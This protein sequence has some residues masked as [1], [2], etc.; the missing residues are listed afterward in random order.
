MIDA[1]VHM[2]DPRRFDYPWLSQAPILDRPFIPSDLDGEASG[3]GAIFVQADCAGTQSLDE[4]RWVA[5]LDW[6]GLRGIVAG[7]DLRSPDLSD[8]LDALATVPGV[9]GVRHL[10]QGEDE[11]DWADDDAL[12]AGLR[13]L[14]ARGLTFDACVHRG[15]LTALAPLLESVP[16]VKVVIDHLGKPAVDA[17]IDDA[18]GRQW[19]DSMRRLA[20][21]PLTHVKL[22][23]LAPEAADRSTLDHN[24]DA[25]VTAGLELFGAERAMI[26]SDWPVS[27]RLG[28]GLRP[29]K[30]RDRVL[31]VAASVGADRDAV[32][33]GTA[34]R[35]Y[36]L[37]PTT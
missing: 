31:R 28:A 4:A 10:L 3:Y 17:G 23:G 33:T 12:R 27:A 11:S 26:G 24:G 30:W 34:E 1:H 13:V 20:E 14:A 2:W 7:A 8:H 5:D 9:V 29:A 22:S 37:A 35:F 21:R 15:Q 16:D 32:D 6:S 19:L 36:G 18:A 25:F